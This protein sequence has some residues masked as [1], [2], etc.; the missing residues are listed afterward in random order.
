M[1]ERP[2]KNGANTTG[3]RFKPGNPGSP[4]RAAGSRNKAPVSSRLTKA[5][6]FVAVTFGRPSP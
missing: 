5:R 1:T 4:G 3:G 6:R 2:T